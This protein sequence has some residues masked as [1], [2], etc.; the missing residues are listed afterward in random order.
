MK[1]HPPSSLRLYSSPRSSSSGMSHSNVWGRLGPVCAAWVS[2]EQV[3]TY[4][5]TET[6]NRVTTAPLMRE[7]S[8]EVRPFLT[9]GTGY[10]L[11]NDLH[12]RSL[13]SLEGG[14]PPLVRFR[15]SGE[16]LKKVSRFNYLYI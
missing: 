13:S 1:T 16:I 11:R 2:T 8:C 9:H 6:L 15:K 14:A 5:N 4:S 12:P 3:H 7:L 10:R